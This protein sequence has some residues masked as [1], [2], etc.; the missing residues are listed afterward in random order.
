MVQR[1]HVRTIT[2]D[3]GTKLLRMV[4]RSSG[5]VVRG[6]ERR[7]CCCRRRPADT[8]T[9][10]HPSK[11]IALRTDLGQSDLARSS[12]GSAQGELRGLPIRSAGGGCKHGLGLRVLLGELLAVDRLDERESLGVAVA[13]HLGVQLQASGGFVGAEPGVVD[14]VRHVLALEIRLTPSHGSIL[15]ASPPS[16]DPTS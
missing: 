12:R 10:P 13:G 11:I 5:S 3:E 14:L 2:N 4:R 1:V 15:Q 16:A 7:W 8:R 6:D 9:Q